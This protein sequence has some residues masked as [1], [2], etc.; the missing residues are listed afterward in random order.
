M[1]RFDDR[2]S[3][4]FESRG[5]RFASVE[6]GGT[7]MTRFIDD[8]DDDLFFRSHFAHANRLADRGYEQVRSVYRIGQ[9][10]GAD[11]F[12]EGCNFEKVEKDLENGWLNVR[13][14]GGDWG[15]VREFARI[16]FDRA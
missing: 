5:L 2:Q 11:P 4:L 6:V 8:D 15:S 10:A 1:S 12:N 7:A 16:G 14:G 13:V 9:R 3:S